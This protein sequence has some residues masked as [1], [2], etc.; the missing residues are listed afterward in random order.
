MSQKSLLENQVIEEI[1]RERIYYYLLNKR[2]VDF[3]LLISPNFIYSNKLNESIKNSNFYKSNKISISAS[4]LLNNKDLSFYGAIVTT[5]KEFYKWLKLRIGYFEELKELK[6]L[7]RTNYVSDGICGSLDYNLL[8][9][10]SSNPNYLH[11]S[12]CLDRYKQSLDLYLSKE[13]LILQK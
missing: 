11:P 10:L 9:E 6:S 12:I 4:D 8:N 1:L 13:S 7:D 3:W 5:D 2:S